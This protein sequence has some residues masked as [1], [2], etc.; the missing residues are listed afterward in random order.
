MMLA[1]KR[2]T[3]VAL[4]GFVFLL[5]AA[6]QFDERQA[7][8]PGLAPEEA[9]ADSLLPAPGAAGA[10]PDA[11]LGKTPP[12]TV[13]PSTLG[14]PA[15][16]A[17]S[18]AGICDETG[19]VCDEQ[20]QD[21]QATPLCDAGDCAACTGCT[22]DGVCVAAGAVNAAAACQVCDPARSASA[23]S[24][25]D[26]VACEDGA[27]C[28]IDDVCQGGACVGAARPCDDGVACNGTESCDD[29][30]DVC[31]QGEAQCGANAFCDLATS[32]CVDSCDGC[33]IGGTCVASGAE[34]P[35]DPCF[36]C[37]PARSSTAFSAVAGKACGAG[38]G[39]CSG[40]DTCDAAGVCQPNHAALGSAC[41]N[42]NAAP[43]DGADSCNGAGVCL[44]N[45]AA[46]GSPCDDGRFCTTGDACLGGV[47]SASGLRNCGNPNLEC[48]DALA[49]CRCLGCTVNGTC[50]AA[51]TPSMNGCQVCDPARSTVGLSVNAG[52]NC[53]SPATECSGQDTCNA[54]GVCQP[55]HLAAQT[56]CT[57][58]AGGRC[59]GDGLTCSAPAPTVCDNPCERASGQTCVPLDPGS[60]CE[61]GGEAGLCSADGDCRPI[62]VVGGLL[63]GCVLR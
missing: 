61:L 10:A 50:V 19:C 46:N 14:G 24:N 34:R 53:G 23:W 54:Q 60:D 56:P 9:G 4:S 17:G 8:R 27:F 7:V 18:G 28:T 30:G 58:V 29:V 33:V 55:N 41:G 51:G 43:C 11:P 35:G 32:E 48:D 39:V 40:Q 42:A 49:T 26:G 38:P 52:Q 47:C 20:T 16:A 62:C 6:C 63:D 45:A 36:V 31:V 1:S 12:K 59:Q 5:A 21:C 2:R 37:D 25:A 22:I 3:P 13:D 44:T 15:V 57:S